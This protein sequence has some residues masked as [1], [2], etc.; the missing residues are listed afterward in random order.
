MRTTKNKFKPRDKDENTSH[1]W[2][3]EY[4]RHSALHLIHRQDFTVL[5]SYHGSIFLS[6]Y[7]FNEVKLQWFSCNKSFTRGVNIILCV[8]PAG[9]CCSPVIASFNIFF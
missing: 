1:D 6:I 7:L 9:Q 3:G 2:S 8:W 4:V 5:E